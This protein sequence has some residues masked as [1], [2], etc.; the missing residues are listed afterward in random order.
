MIPTEP[1]KIRNTLFC[2]IWGAVL[3]Y[4]PSAIL[5]RIYAVT[6]FYFWCCR[7]VFFFIL[8]VYLIAFSGQAQTKPNKSG[9]PVFPGWYADPE[10]V[11]FSKQYW[12]YPTYSDKYEKQ[13]FFDAFSSPDLVPWTK[14]PRIPDHTP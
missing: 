5:F 9:N 7:S 4:K 11:I 13:V 1:F 3:I 2:N 8:L 10:G 14:P 12:I 6:G